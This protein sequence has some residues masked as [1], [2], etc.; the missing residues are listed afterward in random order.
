MIGALHLRAWPAGLPEAEV[1]V[2]RIRLLCFPQA[3]QGND[4]VAARARMWHALDSE[5]KVVLVRL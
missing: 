1:V 3:L 4:H 5:D 2:L